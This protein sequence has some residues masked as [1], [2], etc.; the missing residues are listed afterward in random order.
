MQVRALFFVSAALR[1]RPQ[2]HVLVKRYL[3]RLFLDKGEVAPTV[4]LPRGDRRAKHVREKIW[5]GAPPP[6]D[7][8]LR[9][10][11]LDGGVGECGASLAADG[12]VVLEDFPPALAESEAARPRLD[13]IL[14]LPAPLRLKRVLPA[15]ASLGVDRLWL[16]GAARVE[17]AYFGAD[18]LKD[19]PARA[20]HQRTVTPE[21][22]VPG[23]LRDLLIE[24][25]EQSGDAA[26][27]RVAVCRSLRACLP[28]ADPD[29][30]RVFGHPDRGDG[31]EVLDD[32]T[33][34]FVAVARAAP[35]RD[36]VADSAKNRAV[37]A[38]GPD[39]GWAEPEELLLLEDAGFAPATLGP[40]TLRTDVALISL[41][42]LL[43]DWLEGGRGS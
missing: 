36:I 7:A 22:V 23:K 11:V 16:V 20:P 41:V 10:G 5:R 17:K 30:L 12:G 34:R 15:L 2:R 8:T 1:R 18:F 33:G 3:N 35:L 13:V 24:G 42:A 6:E 31:F 37:L 28:E 14:A 19:L 39:R 25:A 32:A 38:V 4:T 26:L 9:V 29:A 43:G 21:A 40:R 27:P